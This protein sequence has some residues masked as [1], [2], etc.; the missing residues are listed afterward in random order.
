MDLFALDKSK[1]ARNAKEYR[2]LVASDAKWIARTPDDV[3]QLRREK[4]NPLSEISEQAFKEF[5]D[6]LQF[7]NGGVCSGSYKP[8]ATEIPLSRMFE[9]F[10]RFGMERSYFLETHEA[11]CMGSQCKFSFWSFC[12]SSCG[13]VLSPE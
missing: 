2:A 10:E 11:E 13:T 5:T 3:L 1:L 9:V 7:K 4:N 8:L 12:T 6:K